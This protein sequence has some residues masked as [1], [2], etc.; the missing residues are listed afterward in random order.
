MVRSYMNLDVE[1]R[2][3]LVLVWF[4]VGP[5]TDGGQLYSIYGLRIDSAQEL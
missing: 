3:F 5:T 1:W 2:M 4:D